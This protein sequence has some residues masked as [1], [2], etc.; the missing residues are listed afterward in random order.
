MAEFVSESKLENILTTRSTQNAIDL[1]ESITPVEKAQSV[2]Y[3]RIQ[4]IDPA[5]RSPDAS[6]PINVFFET[7]EHASNAYDRRYGERPKVSLE[8]FS[9]ATKQ[10][11]GDII[12]QHIELKITAHKPDSLLDDNSWSSLITPGETHLVEYG[13]AGSSKNDLINGNGFNDGNIF[14]PSRKRILFTTYYYTFNITKKGEIEFIIKGMQNGNFVF[15]KI[16]LGD[17]I[18]KSV[19]GK[20][21]NAPDRDSTDNLA[22]RKKLQ[23]LLTHVDSTSMKIGKSK[24]KKYVKLI[25]VLNVLTADT[26]ERRAREWGYDEVSMEIGLF[27]PRVP[28]ASD[29]YHRNGDEIGSFMLPIDDVKMIITRSTRKGQKLSIEN[30]I[31]QF[32]TIVN[33]PTT[34]APGKLSDSDRLGSENPDVKV[35][36][37]DESVSRRKI[38]SIKIFDMKRDMIKLFPEDRLSGE[39]A[40]S[41]AVIKNKLRERGVPFISLGK[42]LS[43]IEDAGF[44]VIMDNQIQRAK[45][46]TAAQH[47]KTRSQVTSKSLRDLVKEDPNAFHQIWNSAIEGEI[48]MMG[49]FAFD[50]FSILW[51]DF[52]VNIWSGP[53]NVRTRIDMLNAS[54]FQTS[55][56]VISEGTDPLNTKRRLTQAQLDAT[57]KIREAQQKMQMAMTRLRGRERKRAIEKAREDMRKANEQLRLAR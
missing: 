35:R 26:I 49:N 41:R 57:D 12:E 28:P 3:I 48:V 38:L 5:T 44:E 56:A 43:F 46:D 37:I 34:W 51:L 53:F 1:L 6:G 27:N 17:V 40:R 55:V 7:A 36:V 15:R 21:P 16:E 14:V 30:F 50:V 52:G 45:I 4:R 22:V 47:L 24:K 9:V 10:N 23:Q 18:D 11:Y 32:L 31:T 29:K 2:P 13:W 8:S 54:G 19:V 20:G 33:K 39:K 42:A 25:D